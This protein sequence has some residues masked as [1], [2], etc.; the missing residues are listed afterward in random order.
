MLYTQ[1]RITVG[2][3]GFRFFNRIEPFSTPYCFAQP[4]L[5]GRKPRLTRSNF[6]QRFLQHFIT[7]TM[8]LQTSNKSRNCISL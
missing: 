1:L 5:G 2:V 6:T 8:T 7:Y 3:V 4:N